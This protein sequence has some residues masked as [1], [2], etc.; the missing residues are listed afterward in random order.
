M[1]E[2]TW[3]ALRKTAEDASKPLPKDTYDVTVS[4]AE[5]TVAST[6]SPMIKATLD[7]KSGPQ[8][9]N[10]KLFTQFVMKADAPFAVQMFF[11]NLAAFGLGEQFFAQLPDD[12]EAGMPIIADALVGRSARANVEPRPYQGVE[13][14]NVT[15]FAPPLGGAQAASVASSIA[16]P[17]VPGQSSAAPAG[18]PVPQS[19]PTPGVPQGSGPAAPPQLNF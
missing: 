9:G 4:K 5:S 11:T 15:G 6:G 18:P 14:D 17:P 7:V 16:G 12:L 19:P 1:A 13:R 3:G 10:R 8:A 2:T